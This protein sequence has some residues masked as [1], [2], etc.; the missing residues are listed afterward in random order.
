MKTNNNFGSARIKGLF[1]NN[2][3][4]GMTQISVKS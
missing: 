3:P 1:T 2:V 4:N